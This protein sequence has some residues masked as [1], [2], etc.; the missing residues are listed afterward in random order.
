MEHPLSIEGD[1]VG[2]LPL[3]PAPTAV[4]GG[5]ASV[6]DRWRCDGVAGHPGM[7]TAAEARAVTRWNDEATGR[8][9]RQ[10]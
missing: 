7:H 9:L 2:A 3:V 5:C 10:R 4:R 6:F 1:P 8:R